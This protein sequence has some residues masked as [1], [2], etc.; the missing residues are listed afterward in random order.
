MMS[1]PVHNPYETPR[2]LNEPRFHDDGHI[3]QVRFHVDQRLV[4]RCLRFEAE[5]RSWLRQALFI[6]TTM[7]LAGMIVVVVADWPWWL[8]ATLVVVFF[9]LN[10]VNVFLPDVWASYWTRT[11]CP[12][13]VAMARP[14]HYQ[15]ELAAEEIRWRIDGL[16]GQQ[17]LKAVSEA[18]YLGDLLLVFPVRSFVLPIPRVAE[19]EPDD[20]FGFCRLFAMR[21]RQ[22]A[23]VADGSE[24][25]SPR[26]SAS[27]HLA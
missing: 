17:N 24:R 15:V 18:Y 10:V 6:L 27:Q 11:G 22:E 21:L 1:V 13:S 4:Y 7:L 2:T 23:E 3:V 20:F 8:G 5:R 12:P 26:L 9:A 14:G 19:F 25:R 16:E